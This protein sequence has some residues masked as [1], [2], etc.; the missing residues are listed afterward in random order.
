MRPG[1]GLKI[2]DRTPVISA[3]VRDAETDLASDNIKSVYLDGRSIAKF[4]YYRV[5]NEL[6]FE[7]GR[8]L[9]RK[10]HWVKVMVKDP[11]GEAEVRTWRFK[12]VRRR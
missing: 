8:R 10:G 11:Q 1:P 9:A 5:A 12:V 7:P 3:K 6:T 2:R 4:N